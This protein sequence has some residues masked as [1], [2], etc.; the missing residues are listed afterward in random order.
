MKQKPKRTR[1]QMV[2]QRLTRQLNSAALNRIGGIKRRVFDLKQVKAFGRLHCSYRE[3]ASLMATSEQTIHDRMMEE[4]PESKE[5][6][7]LLPKDWGQFRLAY[8]KGCASCCRDLR[9]KQTK[10][11]LAGNVRMLIHL[12]QHL[13]GQVP[14]SAMDIKQA[15]TEDFEFT[16]LAN[17]DDCG[18][19]S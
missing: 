13:L 1:G 6:R 4:I 17:P 3:L 2:K 8:E 19:P 16:I 9:S 12:G 11:A 15:I 18:S 14:A 10:M 5:Q 7:A